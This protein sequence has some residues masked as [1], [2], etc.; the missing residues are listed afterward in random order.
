M[1]PLS[2]QRLR[3]IA[4]LACDFLA[5]A[6]EVPLDETGEALLAWAAARE[7]WQDCQSAYEAALDDWRRS[8]LR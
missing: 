6:R 2:I 4:D 8:G 3:E 1:L 7:R 5:E